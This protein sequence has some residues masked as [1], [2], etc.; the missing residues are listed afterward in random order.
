MIFLLS[1]LVIHAQDNVGIGTTTPNST[2]KLDITAND[3]GVLVP[4]LTTAQ[5]LAIPGP[6][7]GLLVYDTNFN[8]FYFYST[9]SSAWTSLCSAGATGATGP[10]GPTGATG[11]GTSGPT[12]N[13]GPTGATG[14]TGPAGGPTG[15]TGPIGTIGLPVFQYF[16]APGSINSTTD[17]A[18]IDSTVATGSNFQLPLCTSVPVG[19]VIIV[20]KIIVGPTWYYNLNASG[21]DL[22]IAVGT[23]PSQ[24]LVVNAGI[25]LTSCHLV[26]DGISNWY[27]W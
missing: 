4:R 27:V 16:F 10:T 23:P 2:A 25:Y 11:I 12:G 9:A 13:I 26:S 1:A 21:G 20:K 18:I 6:A 7:N 17:I 14:A 8:C 15:P 5:R 24:T 19:K 3:K 22:I